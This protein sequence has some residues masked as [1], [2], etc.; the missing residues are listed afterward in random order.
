MDLGKVLFIAVDVQPNGGARTPGA[1]QSEDDART[2][3]KNESQALGKISRDL[4]FFV[5]FSHRLGDQRGWQIIRGPLGDLISSILDPSGDSI[6]DKWQQL[7]PMRL[8]LVNLSLHP[9]NGG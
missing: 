1:T 9:G 5:F 6:L 7:S 2:I 8:P 4:F 3:C